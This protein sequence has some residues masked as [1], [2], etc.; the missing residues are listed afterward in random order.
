MPSRSISRSSSRPRGAEI[1]AGVGALRVDAGT[2]VRRADG[3]QALSYARS[4]WRE[5]DDRVGPLEAEHVADRR[6]VALPSALHRVEVA[7]QRAAIR[8]LARARHA[9]PWRD[10]TPA[11]PASS[12]RPAPASASRAAGCPARRSG[13][14]ASRR[15]D[16][17]RRAASRGT[18]PSRCRDPACRSGPSRARGSRRWASQIA[19]PLH[20]VHR[21]IQM[22]I[23]YE[24]ENR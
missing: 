23:D 19:V 12:P 20:G 13:R 15:T 21:Q 5:R 11:A 8:D 10:T 24:H 22:G 17:R 18:T 7:V 4:R 16:P 1:A 2:V 9:P 6:A 3:A 14:S